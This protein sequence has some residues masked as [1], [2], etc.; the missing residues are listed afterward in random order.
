MYHLPDLSQDSD[1]LLQ[2]E[3]QRDFVNATS[4]SLEFVPMDAQFTHNY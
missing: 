2:D 1:M 3:N 4:S